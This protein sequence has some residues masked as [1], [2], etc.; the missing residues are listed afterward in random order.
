MRIV[1]EPRK[2]LTYERQ[3]G[4]AVSNGELIANIDSDSRLTPGWIA[5]VLASFTEDAMNSAKPLVSVS[6]PF[7]Y[8][9]LTTTQRIF[10][11]GFYLTHGAPTR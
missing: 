11:Q 10:V 9:D 4:F 6:G 2:G 3:A 5:A 1:D 7:L 8:F